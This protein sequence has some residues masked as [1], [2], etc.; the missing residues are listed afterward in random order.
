MYPN[1]TFASLCPIISSIKSFKF[2]TVKI[3]VLTF[4]FVG[5]IVLSLDKYG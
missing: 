2:E 1:F 4:G 3:Y 5:L